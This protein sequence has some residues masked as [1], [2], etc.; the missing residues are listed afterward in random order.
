MDVYV[1][2]H[3]SHIQLYATLWTGVPWVPLSMGFS[4]QGYW[5]RLPCPPPRDLPHSGIEPTFLMSP[6]LA[7][8]LFTTSANWEAIIKCI[9]ASNAK[10][11]SLWVKPQ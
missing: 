3:F 10:T 2:S 9:S 5:S 11:L 4:R 1:L 6:A 8:R 7:N